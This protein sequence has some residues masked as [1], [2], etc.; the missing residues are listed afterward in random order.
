MIN[1]TRL[2][3]DRKLAIIYGTLMLTLLAVTIVAFMTLERLGAASDRV[4]TRYSPQLDR[5]SD[6]QMLMFRISLEARH[7]MLVQAGPARDE[8]FNRIGGFRKEMLDKLDAFEATLSTPEGKAN[9]AKIREADKL[10][11]RLAG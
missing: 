5:I 2:P 10:F 3:I 8:T 9:A 1:T 7:A 11:W 6:I 4:A